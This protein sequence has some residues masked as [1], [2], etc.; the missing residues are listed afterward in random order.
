MN[1]TDIMYQPNTALKK[2]MIHYSCSSVAVK[3]CPQ[4]PEYLLRLIMIIF[5]V[6][7]NV[8][9]NLGYDYLSLIK[10]VLV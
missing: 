2:Q 1:V 3:L 4:R 9:F 6:V 10:L 8:F 7:H 5:M